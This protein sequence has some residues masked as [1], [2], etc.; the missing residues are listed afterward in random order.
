MDR[1]LFTQAL[2]KFL[3][4]LIVIALL[5]FIPAGSLSYINGWIFIGILFIPMFMP[6]AHE[7]GSGAIKEKARCKRG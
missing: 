6:G 2:T 4:G 3:A 7:K 5:L 1:K